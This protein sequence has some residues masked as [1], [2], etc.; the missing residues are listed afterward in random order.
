MI[1]CLVRVSLY[2]KDE[3]YQQ[4]AN[5]QPQNCLLKCPPR[6]FRIAA[7]SGRTSTCVA[8]AHQKAATIEALVILRLLL[9][10]FKKLIFQMKYPVKVMLEVGFYIVKLK[11]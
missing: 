7:W 4:A 6:I 10:N 5:L 11:K 3:N 9:C 8:V 1:A 2:N